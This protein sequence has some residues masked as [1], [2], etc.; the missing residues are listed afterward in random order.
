MSSS[1]VL[2]SS[3]SFQTFLDLPLKSTP[4][5]RSQLLL[6]PPPFYKPTAGAV[7][8]CNST[9]PNTNSSPSL[10]DQLH[11]FSL[12]LLKQTQPDTNEQNQDNLVLSHKPKSTW[13][14]PSRPR[15]KV[16]SLNRQRRPPLPYNPDLTDLPR[17]SSRLASVGPDE[18]SAVID[19]LLPEPPTRETALLILN[20]LRPW[21]KAQQ[22]FLWLRS[23]KF[24]ELDTIF[25]NVAIKNLRYGKQFDAVE[26]LATDMIDS[27]IELDNVT[28]STIITCAKRCS[29]FDRAIHWFERMYKTGLMP[30]E[31]TY[32]A[33]L[34]VYAKLGKVEEVLSLYERARSNGWIPD[35]VAY[36]VLGKMYGEAGDYEGIQYVLQEMKTAGVEPNLVVYNTLLDAMGKAGKPGLARTLFDEMLEKGLRPNE[37]TLTALIK[38]YGKARWSKDAIELWDKMKSN[39]WPMDFILYNTLLSMCA[40]LRM[41][42]E[43]ESLFEDMKK[44]GRCVPDSWS[45]T[46]MVNIYTNSGMGDKALEVFYSMLDNNVEPNV[47]SCTCLIQCFGKAKRIDD[48]VKVFDVLIQRGINP[49]DRLCGCLLSVIAVCKSDQIVKVLNCLTMAKPKLVGLINTLATD[50]DDDDDDVLKEEFRGILTETVVESRRPF[51]NCLIDICLNQNFSKQRAQQLFSLGCLFGLYPGLHVK[52]DRE[53]SLNLRSLSIGAACMAFE[54][55]MEN[56]TAC[57]DKKIDGKESLPNLFSVHTGAGSL[58]LATGLA[59]SFAEYLEKSAFPFKRSEETPGRFVATKQDLILWIDQ[60][61]IQL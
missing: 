23:G 21:Q 45:Y 22:F 43:A 54:A 7:F 18:F 39:N 24:F 61:T 38:I 6:F 12:D 48:V 44:S 32:S 16:L 15:P 28:Y 40:D 19:E 55:W 5:P 59:T 9:P 37:K 31:V 11:P 56:L 53:W 29:K 35:A 14:N 52:R 1:S 2:S 49:D 8:L 51:C 25:Y 41:V 58:K 33:I 20:S 34:D 42:K 10:S 26:I 47:M 57:V 27:G 3:P 50:D 13:I 60:L 36:S 30:D 17:I 4:F 46:A